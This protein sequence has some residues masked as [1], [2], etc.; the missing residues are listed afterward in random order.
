MKQ[1]GS[2]LIEVLIALAILVAI[3]GMFGQSLVSLSQGVNEKNISASLVQIQTAQAT[4]LAAYSNGYASMTDLTSCPAGGTAPSKTKACLIA[5]G[6]SS[7]NPIYGYTI[8]TSTPT[9]APSCATAPCGFLVVAE[10]KSPAFGRK[11]FCVNSDG[12][13]HGEV[14]ST[15]NLTTDAAC[16]ALPIVTAGQPSQA[17]A[18]SNPTSFSHTTVFRYLSFGPGGNNITSDAL[19][20]STPG[21]YIITVSSTLA[22]PGGG[23]SVSCYIYD[24][25]GSLTQSGAPQDSDWLPTATTLLSAGGTNTAL[26]V[27]ITGVTTF[28][29]TDSVYFTCNTNPTINGWVPASE[30]QDNGNFPYYSRGSTYLGMGPTVMTALL[31]SNTAQ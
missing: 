6:L 9:D 7:S 13:L 24:T 22:A 8:T 17:P 28:T 25:A 12:V 23:P 21:T 2:A 3:T 29:S 26:P 30:W 27:N 19:T 18:S 15:L 4:Y 10:P 20:L 11:S 5:Q 1:R 31:V 16:S 14:A